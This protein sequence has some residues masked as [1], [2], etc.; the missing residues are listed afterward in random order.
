[1][2]LPQK[3]S[4]VPEAA[5]LCIPHSHLQTAR[6]GVLEQRWLPREPE[7]EA[8]QA[9]GYLSSGP[10]AISVLAPKVAGCLQAARRGVPGLTRSLKI[11]WRVLWVAGDSQ[12]TVRPTYS[13][14]ARTGRGSMTS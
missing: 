10:E 11:A 4:P 7:A 14:A 12:L 9:C 8:S 5:S 13:G 3:L 2:A 1:M 6:H